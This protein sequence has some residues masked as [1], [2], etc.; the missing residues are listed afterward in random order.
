MKTRYFSFSLII[1]FFLIA[2]MASAQCSFKKSDCE[3]DDAEFEDIFSD[4]DYRS[5]SAYARMSPGDI[6][7]VR[8]VI[9]RGKDYRVF[10]CQDY[11][12]GDVQMQ[13]IK[14]E[15][16]TE[17]YYDKETGI[18]KTEEP[19]YKLDEEGNEVYDEETWEP[20]QIGTKTSYDTTWQTRRYVDEIVVFD[21]HNNEKGSK[22]WK[23]N[24][25]QKTST[26]RAKIT[27]PDGDPEYIG[28]VS[29]LI[30]Y[31]H[32]NYNRFTR[33]TTR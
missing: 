15:R 27:V 19:V 21:S 24:N 7:V 18:V 9:Y 23:K 20:I 8:F 22:I 33:G 32:T 28:C 4:F 13:I 1:S 14:P 11:D 31:R 29:V 5:Q 16:K 2:N 26:L 6:Q 30:G 12:L 10:T 17:R 3:F 25:V